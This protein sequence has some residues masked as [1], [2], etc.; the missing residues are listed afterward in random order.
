MVTG[1]AQTIRRQRV[2]IFVD[3]WNFELSMKRFDAS[4]RADFRKLGPCL[5]R[6]AM[7][8]VDA[9][10]IGEYAG[11]GVYLSSDESSTAEAGLRK[12]ATNTLDR[13]PGIAVTLV[14]RV[15]EASGPKCPGC[16]EIVHRCPSCGGDMRGTEEKGVD[17]R[18][19]TDMIML[20]WVDSYD[21]AVLVSSDADFVPV[22]QFLQTKG[23]K[24]LHA[25]FPPRGAQL[26]Q[27]CWG[28]LNLPALREEF[29]L[30]SRVAPAS[31]LDE[32]T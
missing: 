20:A 4:F 11:M 9:G 16:Y 17:V 24:V 7:E 30:A 29:R 22:A 1:D 14:P 28:S 2:H 32:R 25:Q 18:I 23:K 12:W 21:I 27:K 26:S 10:S 13:F 15:R 19:A 5:V 3:F 6:A 8:L 31:R